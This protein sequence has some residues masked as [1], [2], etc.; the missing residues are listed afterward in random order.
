VASGVVSNLKHFAKVLTYQ[1]KDN[2]VNHVIDLAEFYKT[3][4][5]YCVSDIT[6]KA[7]LKINDSR[8]KESSS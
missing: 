3:Y 4:P 6:S 2:D 8:W 1:L 5:E 7:N